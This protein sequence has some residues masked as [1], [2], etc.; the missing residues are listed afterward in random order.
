MVDAAKWA[1]ESGSAGDIVVVR[2]DVGWVPHVVEDDKRLTPVCN[3]DGEMVTIALDGDDADGIPKD[4][5]EIYY[6]GNY[7]DDNNVI[8]YFDGGTAS[9][10]N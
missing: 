3:C 6:D 10:I 8:Q 5:V 9:G 4:E 2:L 7:E 1:V